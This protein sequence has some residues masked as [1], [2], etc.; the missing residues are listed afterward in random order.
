MRFARKLGLPDWYAST[1]VEGCTEP[2]VP[3]IGLT[4]L[5]AIRAQWGHAEVVHIAL[6]LSGQHLCII[7]YPGQTQHALR[8]WRTLDFIALWQRTA[9]TLEA[10]ADTLPPEAT[11]VSEIPC[12]GRLGREQ[13]SRPYRATV[14][15]RWVRALL[16][17]LGRWEAGLAWGHGAISTGCPHGPQGLRRSEGLVHNSTGPLIE[18]QRC[19]RDAHAA[20]WR[21]RPPASLRI[22]TRR[23]CAVRGTPP[24]A[25]RGSGG[26]A[27]AP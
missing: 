22:D 10:F 26:R 11:V 23:A 7:E 15:V 14:A 13:L 24:S 19:G 21:R 27:P 20:R 5:P 2:V 12:L 17:A 1:V 18:A 9:H 16:S 4:D 6:A 25:R 8:G 3:K